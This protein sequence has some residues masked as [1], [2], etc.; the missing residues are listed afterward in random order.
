MSA[1]PWPGVAAE[2]AR[3]IRRFIASSLDGAPSEPFEALALDIH[4]W[5]VTQDPVLAALPRFLRVRRSGA[6]EADL[7]DRMLELAFARPDL[8]EPG[9]ANVRLR[10]CELVFVEAL[11]RYL[12][13]VSE[14]DD[15]WLAVGSVRS[16]PLA[17]G[18]CETYFWDARRSYCSRERRIPAWRSP[19][20]SPSWR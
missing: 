9:S 4:R 8:G 20:A 13:G 12:R 6:S 11:R 18:S 10:L 5:Q 17:E 7:L 3:R 1:N 15:G 16:M 14:A 19:A 2:L